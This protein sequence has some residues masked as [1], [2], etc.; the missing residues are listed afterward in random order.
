MGQREFAA[1]IRCLMLLCLAVQATPAWPENLEYYGYTAREPD[2][3]GLAYY[4]GRYQDASLGIFTQRDPVGLAGGIND[5]AYVEGNPANA[6]DPMGLAPSSTGPSGSSIDSILTYLGTATQASDYVRNGYPPDYMQL[7]PEERADA[8]RFASNLNLLGAQILGTEFALLTMPGTVP[9]IWRN[10][11]AAIGGCAYGFTSSL[12]ASGSAAQDVMNCA[13]SATT[14]M[15]LANVGPWICKSPEVSGCLM[16]V[17]LFWG[18][19]NAAMQVPNRYFFVDGTVPRLRDLNVYMIFSTALGGHLL[20]YA[21]PLV[22]AFGPQ[23]PQLFGL[24][25]AITYALITAP[26]LIFVDTPLKR[27]LPYKKWTL[28][29]FYDGFDAWGNDRINDIIKRLSQ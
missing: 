2:A 22:R 23:V 14:A 12:L 6:I 25:P 3:S 9:L 24:G 20:T 1:T 17:R 19:H 27:N 18:V 21:R 5:Y 29:Y 26:Y 13:A 8:R 15:L 16:A 10:G 4:R 28:G 7:S 11:T